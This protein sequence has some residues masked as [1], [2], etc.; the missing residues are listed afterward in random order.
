[1]VWRKAF[2]SKC[3]LQ[4]WNFETKPPHGGC[5]AYLLAFKNCKGTQICT[6]CGLALTFRAFSKRV[7]LP[8]KAVPV[9]FVCLFPV[10]DLKP[11]VDIG[12]PL[13]VMLEVVGVLPHVDVENREHA[14]GK[15][16]ILILGGKNTQSPGR[17]YYEPCIAG[18]E[19]KKSGFFEGI[20]HCLKAAQ[21]LFYGLL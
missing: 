1:M 17:L 11:V 20:L 8:A 10:D 12:S 15:R 14:Q 19:Y 16:G 6:G 13:V 9:I 7:K 21:L 4:K 2:L 5:D 3:K 18:A